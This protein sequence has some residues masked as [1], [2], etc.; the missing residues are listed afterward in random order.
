M[1]LLPILLPTVYRTPT[2]FMI[3]RPLKRHTNACRGIAAHIARPLKWHL[4]QLRGLSLKLSL[5]YSL[6]L[7]QTLSP[8]VPTQETILLNCR[9]PLT[10]IAYFEYI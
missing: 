4:C 5:L 9:G 10:I 1:G 3:A 2:P 6:S 8:L 7:V